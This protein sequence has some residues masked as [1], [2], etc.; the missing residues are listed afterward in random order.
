MTTSSLFHALLLLAAAGASAAAT[1][2][3]RQGGDECCFQLASV[4][5]VN[6]TVVESHVGSLLLG[7]PFQQGGFCLDG[8]AGTV[9]DGLGHGCFMRAPAYQFACWAAGAVGPNAFA[10][11]RAGPGG[12]PHLA[13]DGR[14]GVF[15]ACPV[16]SSAPPS[17]D[18]YSADKPDAAGCLAVALALVDETP[19][20]AAAAAS[21]AEAPSSSS[22][23]ISARPAPTPPLPRRR[24]AQDPART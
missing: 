4:G 12:R 7:G 9:R 24:R 8:A 10:V 17:Y 15:L 23:A 20:C 11:S 18:I 22:V 13:Y 16:R 21:N 2:R 6:E 1:L 14:P 19:A 5:T 3:P